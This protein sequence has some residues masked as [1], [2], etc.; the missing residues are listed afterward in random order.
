MFVIKNLFYLFKVGQKWH[1]V[2]DA[3]T[4]IMSGITIE[5][6]DTEKV[7]P[8]IHKHLASNKIIRF[9]NKTPDMRNRHAWRK[10]I[11]IYNDKDV[12]DKDNFSDSVIYPDYTIPPATVKRL[13]HFLL[14]NKVKFYSIKNET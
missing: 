7:L 12:Y 5:C 3:R 6:S 8:K 2:D 11:R 1:L 4:H 10:T 9:W 14:K 13:Y